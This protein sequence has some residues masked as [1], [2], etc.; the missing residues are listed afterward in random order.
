M[1]S[2]FVIILLILLVFFTFSIVT[3]D[4]GTVTVGKVRTPAKVEK[5]TDPLIGFK[6]LIGVENQS[7]VDIIINGNKV[8]TIPD[9]SPI[10]DIP[11]SEECVNEYQY[12]TI[13][14]YHCEV[15]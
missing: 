3:A 12:G 5:R 1:K 2:T 10:I 13:G 14:W 11:I 4:S 15:L 8:A 7:N 9:N 6:K